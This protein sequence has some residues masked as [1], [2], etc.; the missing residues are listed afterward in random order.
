MVGSRGQSE[1]FYAPKLGK[2]GRGPVEYRFAA[3]VIHFVKLLICSPINRKPLR[4]RKGRAVQYRRDRL[5]W[6]WQFT[7]RPLRPLVLGLVAE[8]ASNRS[9]IQHDSDCQL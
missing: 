2:M 8:T 4:T 9:S 3:A 1:D 6:A 5:L 7:H